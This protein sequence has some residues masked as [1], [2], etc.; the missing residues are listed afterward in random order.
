MKLEVLDK[1]KDIETLCREI[2]CPDGSET[3]ISET[4]L[5]KT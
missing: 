3:K 5:I 4:Y 2:K 1:A